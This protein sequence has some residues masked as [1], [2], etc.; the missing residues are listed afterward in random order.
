M[1]ASSLSLGYVR[2]EGDNLDLDDDNFS[3][4]AIYGIKTE[5]FFNSNIAINAG[6][7][8]KFGFKIPLALFGLLPNH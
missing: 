6:Y 3:E 8:P 5:Y 2:I 4:A 1:E 7:T